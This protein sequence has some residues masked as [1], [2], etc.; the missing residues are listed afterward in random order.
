LEARKREPNGE[1]GKSG[2]IPDAAA[3]IRAVCGFAG[4]A[5]RDVDGLMGLVDLPTTILGL[6]GADPLHGPAGRLLGP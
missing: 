5:P 1:S 4:L 3:C 2:G 6:A